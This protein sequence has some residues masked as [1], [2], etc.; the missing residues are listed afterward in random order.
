[1]YWT[2]MIYFKMKTLRSL[3]KAVCFFML[4]NLKAQTSPSVETKAAYT[5]DN[6]SNKSYAINNAAEYTLTL[7]TKLFGHYNYKTTINTTTNVVANIN[8]FG[9]GLEHKLLPK[10]SFKG[11]AGLASTSSFNNN[12]N[13]LTTDIMLKTEALKKQTI[14]LGFKRQIENFNAQLL[15][16]ELINNTFYTKY[17]LDTNFKVG[18]KTQYNHTTLSDNNIKQ[19]VALSAH[20]N[21]FEKPLL[22]TGINYEHIGFKNQ[23]PQQYFSPKKF[24]TAQ[25]FINL[26]QDQDKVAP[27]QFFYKLNVI[28]GFQ[29]IDDQTS[30]STQK[31]QGDFGYKFSSQ[32]LLSLYGTHST[33]ASANA[34]GAEFNEVGLRFKWLLSKP[35]KS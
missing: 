29:N 13:Q 7:K 4:I 28:Y 11:L 12:Y 22:K 15:D 1:M 35:N 23:V 6:S 17:T 8:N 16:Q 26:E 21:F 5:F 2:L 31:F 27:K 34:A 25:V 10:L 18:F 32:S 3:T 14:E 33:I 30:K 24:N 19:L 20:Y 9:V